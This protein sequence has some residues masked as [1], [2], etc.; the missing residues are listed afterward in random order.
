MV[1]GNTLPDASRAPRKS[2]SPYASNTSGMNVAPQT[3]IKARPA[4][5]PR[6]SSPPP[7][8][9]S[10][11]QYS[12]GH[13][14]SSGGGAPQSVPSGTQSGSIGGVGQGGGGG[15]PNPA[16]ARRREA[17]QDRREKRQ[18]RKEFRQFIPNDETYQS[19]ISSLRQQLEDFILSNKDQ[20]G[21]VRENFRLT[22]QR[23]GEERTRALEDMESDFGARGMLNSS[24]YL[25]S[26]GKYNNEFQTKFGDL[27]RD[28]DSN[29]EDLLESLG[30][31]RR[32]NQGERQNARAEAIRRRTQQF[33]QM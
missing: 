9:T 22:N 17:R 26:V 24:E 2:S 1:Y 31:Y 5:S 25:D 29:I 7:S 30:M 6:V 11:G 12:G 10:S 27:T 20:R 8:T 13:T 15:G 3:T 16:V 32:A 4:P 14:Y 18:E 23:M 19:S 33:G 21:D 28:R